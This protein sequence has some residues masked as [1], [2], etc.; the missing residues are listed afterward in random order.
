MRRGGKKYLLL[1]KSVGW[2]KKNQPQQWIFLTIGSAFVFFFSFSLKI[3][4]T[5]SPSFSWWKSMSWSHDR[6]VDLEEKEDILFVKVKISLMGKCSKMV[7]LIWVPI[8]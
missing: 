5:L 4:Q 1:K 2:Q 6:K 3:S 8:F 7:H